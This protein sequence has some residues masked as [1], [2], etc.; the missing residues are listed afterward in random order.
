MK[1]GSRLKQARYNCKPRVLSIM[2]LIYLK[3]KGTRLGMMNAQPQACLFLHPPPI[4]KE[5]VKKAKPHTLSF[6]AEW[7][8]AASAASSSGMLVALRPLPPNAHIIWSCLQF[9]RRVHALRLLS[10]FI[11]CRQNKSA[12]SEKGETKPC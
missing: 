5:E 10:S 1:R 9:P 7:M 4:S 12:S 3:H 8:A 6:K 2:R 11:I